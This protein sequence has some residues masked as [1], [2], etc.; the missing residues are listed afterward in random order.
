MGTLRQCGLSSHW[1]QRSQPKASP[2]PLKA[3]GSVVS[4]R[5][6]IPGGCPRAL[7]GPAM[8]DTAPVQA[9]GQDGPRSEHVA[10]FRIN[11]PALKAFLSKPVRL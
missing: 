2:G 1:D 4:G 5:C 11:I 3:L 7:P 9:A 10:K 6:G 8:G